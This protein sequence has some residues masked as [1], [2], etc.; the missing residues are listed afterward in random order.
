[1]LTSEVAGNARAND[2]K[3]CGEFSGVTERRFA[4]R[5]PPAG[6]DP[7]RPLGT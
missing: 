4:R 3:L 2:A 6:G 1:V 7:T 5:Q